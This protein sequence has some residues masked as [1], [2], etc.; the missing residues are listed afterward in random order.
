MIGN[1]ITTALIAS[2]GEGSEKVFYNLGRNPKK[3][4]ELQL[5]LQQ[6]PNGLKAMVL[7]GKMSASFNAPIKKKSLAPA[8]AA[9]ASGDKQV[10]KTEKSFKRA[11]ENAHKSGNTQKAFNLKSEAKAAGLDTKNW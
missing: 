9:N 1:E 6:D 4:A 8:P 5:A 10:S 11:Y 7:L 3:L 2:M